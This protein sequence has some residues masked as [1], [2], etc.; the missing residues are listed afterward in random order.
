MTSVLDRAWPLQVPEEKCEASPTVR[1]TR[2]PRARSVIPDAALIVSVGVLLVALAYTRSRG[3]LS[4][5]A[6]LM[7]A[8][9]LLIFV[10]I[11]VRILHRSTSAR[12]RAFL[13]ILFALAQAVIRWAYSPHAFTFSD[14][15][16]HLRS[17]ENVLTTHHLF[18][19]SYALPISPQYPGLE[20]V[21]AELVQVSS[22][23]P[24]VAGVLVASICHVLM[25]TALLLLFREVTASSRVVCLGVVLYML[26]PHAAYFDTSFLYE[27]LALP[28]LVLTVLLAIRFARRRTGRLLNFAG[29]VVCSVIVAIT[30]HVSIV[31]TAGVIA[32]VAAATAAFQASRSMAPR[33]ALCAV[34]VVAVFWLW[35]HF[36]APAT[37]DYLS[38]PGD[39]ILSALAN[40]GNFDGQM[41]LPRPPTPLFDRAMSPFGV[42]VTLGLLV[43]SVRLA[44]SRLPL[45][46]SF[47]A[48]AAG[49]YIL[50]L[51]TR[52]LVENGPELSA[53]M[54]TFTTMF[55]AVAM[56]I[57]LEHLVFNASGRHRR[58]IRTVGRMVVA[59][60]LTIVLF[61]ASVVSSLPEW[62]QRLPGKFWV[63]GFAS[64][65]DAVG[66]S[67]AEWA[68][69][70]LSPGARFFGDTASLTLLS[71]VAQLDPIRDPESL[72]YTDRL[73]PE[74][75]A[76]IRS[77]SAVYLDVDW[78][79]TEQPPITGNYFAADINMGPD[80]K[81]L[82]P[83][84]L[85]KFDK[86]RGISRIYD[87]G[88]DRFYDLRWI[89]P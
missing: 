44:R 17:L 66:T 12:D 14:E 78:R 74:N 65:I 8:G 88:Y 51:A 37:L 89:Q 53:R 36:F 57:T 34:A 80:R 72:Y 83:E 6:P 27:T 29:V 43:T 19:P 47:I 20:N 68:D 33:L 50:V 70:Y 9:Q 54:L 56:S 11:V 40:L 22:A 35:I 2:E 73:T 84:L 28:F 87:S 5:A 75:L 61:L 63:D 82:A 24:F 41:S 69:I 71:T 25:A 49:S 15:L 10:F 16:Q 39:Q 76:R 85:F 32:V 62:F 21:T 67:R 13:A 52:L 60:A 81:P 55:T 59:T 64:G 45:E 77:E 58:A 7:W 3:G 42:L 26:N 4:Y 46:R 31:A 38:S 79:M 48:A 30:H 18:H 86:F 23:S 1:A